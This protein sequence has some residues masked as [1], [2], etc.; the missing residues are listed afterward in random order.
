M[1]QQWYSLLWP[2]DA[3]VKLDGTSSNWQTEV[4]IWVNPKVELRTKPSKTIRLLHLHGLCEKTVVL[5]KTKGKI[6][7][8]TRSENCPA[9]NLPH[10]ELSKTHMYNI[11]IMWCEFLRDAMPTQ[12]VG[13]NKYYLEPSIFLN[14]HVSNLRSVWGVDLCQCIPI[15]I[16]GIFNYFTLDILNCQYL[17]TVLLFPRRFKTTCSSVAFLTLSLPRSKS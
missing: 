7:Y 5:C 3:L 17:E 10:M 2:W 14:S 8:K 1:I 12:L 15:I 9:P 6:V 4:S 11:I 16:T 13:H